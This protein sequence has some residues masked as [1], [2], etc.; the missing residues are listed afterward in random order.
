M[1]AVTDGRVKILPE[2]YARGYLDWLGEK[3]D[4]PVSRQLWW[5]HQI[6]IWYAP[7]ASEADLKK[8][9]AGRDDVV[10]QRDDEHDQW[11]ICAKKSIWRKTPMPGHKL[12]REVDVLDTWFSS[13]PWPHST[14]GWPEKRR[15]SSTTIPPARSI[16][17]RDII[18]LWVARMVL[19][20]LVQRRRR[21]VSRG[22]HPSE[23]SRRLWR[24]MS[25]S[26]GNGVDPLDVIDKFG[27]DSL[28]FSLAYLTT[29]T[30]DVRMPVEFECPHCQTRIE[31]TKKNRVLPRI[32]CKKCGQA[33]STQWAS[34]PE[35]LALPRGAVVSERFE[36]GRNFC[37]KLWNAAR[38][39]LMNLEGY[40]P[41]PVADK[42]LAVED[43][44][45]LSRLATVTQQT[46]DALGEYRYADAAR[47][48]YDFAWNEFCSFYV[49]MVKGRLQDDAARAMA[50]RVL[51]HTLDTLLRLLHPHDSVHHGRSL[52]IAWSRRPANADCRG[53]RQR[54]RAS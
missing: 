47:V 40:T 4:W 19:T 13:G 25:K 39:A 52:A 26:K 51:A 1:D 16:T 33:F 10:W 48:L 11:L 35:D 45:I 29:E 31:Q 54:P 34:K 5:G 14:L 44:W 6:P 24:G 22:L 46:T 9:F 17:S 23:D 43:R 7:T 18:T 36:L 49:E 15:S 42:D 53:Q 8:A 41:G 21:A 28:R 20:G 27:A 37:N 30:Q 3:R 50:Q 32:D 38:F 12:T 2:R